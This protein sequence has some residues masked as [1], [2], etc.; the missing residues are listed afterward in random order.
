MSKL[1]EFSWHLREHSNSPVTK[2]GI[3]K[4]NGIYIDFTEFDNS[5]LIEL[6]KNYLSNVKLKRYRGTIFTRFKQRKL[7]GGTHYRVSFTIENTAELYY[8]FFFRDRIYR[9]NDENEYKIISNDENPLNI[10]YKESSK[11]NGEVTIDCR[12]FD[13]SLSNLDEFISNIG[14]N[15]QN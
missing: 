3:A 6:W 2:I 5:D 1:S 15:D 12:R 7:L 4:A 9:L 10:T 13:V 8:L 11:R 14:K